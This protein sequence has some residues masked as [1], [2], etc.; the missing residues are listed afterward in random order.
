MKGNEA[1]L[2]VIKLKKKLANYR[3]T[4]KHSSYIKRQ[5]DALFLKICFVKQLYMFRTDLPS[6]IRSLNT[7]FTATGICHASYIDCLLSAN[8][9]YVSKCQLVFVMLVRL[10]VCY[11]LIH[12]TCQN[13]KWYFSY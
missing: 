3:V 7:V 12:D 9:C 8:R 13:V 5:R 1:C 2:N 6:I 4:H 11:Q 10:T